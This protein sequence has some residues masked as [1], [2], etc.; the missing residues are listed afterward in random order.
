MLGDFYFIDGAPAWRDEAFTIALEQFF[1]LNANKYLAARNHLPSLKLMRVVVCKR[2]PNRPTGLND[3][4]MMC[5]NEL[6]LY[7]NIK[8]PLWPQTGVPA[9]NHAW[10]CYIR[11]FLSDEDFR[12]T[13]KEQLSYNFKHMTPF[14]APSVNS[15][16]FKTTPGMLRLLQTAPGFVAGRETFT[17]QEV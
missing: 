9:N 7:F 2:R 12:E 1:R 3:T 16:V 8:A 14:G 4:G 5:S 6:G 11:L 10:L 13:A 17:Y 15:L